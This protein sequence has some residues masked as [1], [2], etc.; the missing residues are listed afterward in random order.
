MKRPWQVWLVLAACGVLVA[1]AMAWLTVHALRAD[2]ERAA[3]R[4]AAE[5]EQKVSLALWR[6]DTKLAPLIAEESA[7]PHYY[8]NSFITVEAPRS[9][10]GPAEELAP[11]PLLNPNNSSV[12][13]NFNATA[14]GKWTS[15]QAPP[16][17]LT[18]L[19]CDVGMSVEQIESNR[20]RLDELATEISVMELLAQL[21]EQPVPLVG[22]P[23]SNGENPFDGVEQPS[24]N[25]WSQLAANNGSWYGNGAVEGV[26][27]LS[28]AG[29]GQQGGPQGQQSR[30][31]RGR[32]GL[33][34]GAGPSTDDAF[35]GGQAAVNEDFMSRGGRVQTQVQ[36]EYVKQ[37]SGNTIRPT[38]ATS[39][40]AVVENVTQPLWVGDRLLL[41][42]RV[43][44]DG[45]T[46]VQGSWLNW[47][48]IKQD[49]LAETADLLPTAN[50]LPVRPG[51]DVD[52]TRLM[53]GLPVR[54]TVSH[55]KLANRPASPLEWALAAGWAA[56]ALALLA[57]AGLLWG[58][59]A[60]S[61]R[62]A[63]FVSSVTHE[64][65]TP[66]TTFRM[67]AEMLVRD[68]VP[69]PER[70]REYLETLRTE[71]ERLTHLV[72]NVL[73]YARLERGRNPRRSE[74]TTPGA[75]VE[76]LEPRLGGRAAQSSMQ[77][78][79]TVNPD[80]GNVALLTDVGV[81][82]QILFNLVDNAAKYAAR[83]EDRRIH[84]DVAADQ[85][86]VKFC[87]RDHGPGFFS[88]RDA[89]RSAPFSKSAEEAAET[90]PGVGLGLALCRRLARELGGRLDIDATRAANSG[91]SV[92]LRLPA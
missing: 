76:R 86:E 53:A 34:G 4:A 16:A 90:A 85:G 29:E 31:L 38:G 11:S 39:F 62:R 37:R 43:V 7:R 71:A 52:P 17:D 12:L 1:S 3:A 30:E 45:Q 22:A 27:T 69:S 56:L 55:P 83:A 32:G 6:M 20:K 24:T 13:I 23:K 88:P 58:V 81:V 21:P 33:D 26:P 73:A 60:L 63:A 25:D 35:S 82:E 47:P 2:R 79:C 15:P 10:A 40:D 36:Q 28:A 46:I 44:R 19:A 49:L 65:R 78:A 18:Q 87:V 42:R 77:L 14:G 68:M 61:E 70:R 8:Y 51:E 74:R 66:L 5:L 89:A 91:A 80:A 48:Q 84:L 67:Y 50:L 41:A 75:L 92:T 59:M 54:L 57:V 9:K 64:L 72:D